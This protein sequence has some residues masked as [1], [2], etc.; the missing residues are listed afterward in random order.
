MR[1]SE[2]NLE[3]NAL[4]YNVECS[5]GQNLCLTKQQLTSD[6]LREP[7]S[8]IRE[9]EYGQESVFSASPLHHKVSV[10]DGLNLDKTMAD[11][12]ITNQD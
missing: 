2:N 3:L 1:S 12:W 6:M 11:K 9:D 4:D 7:E 10:M 5:P 8:T